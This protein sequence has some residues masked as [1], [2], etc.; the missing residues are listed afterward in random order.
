MYLSGKRGLAALALLFGLLASCQKNEIDPTPDTSLTDS[1]STSQ[2]GRNYSAVNAWV[3][4]VMNDAYYWYRQLPAQASLDASQSPFDYFEKLVYEP[5]TLDRFSGL[6]DDIDALQSE[7]D[8]VSKIFGISYVLAF[9]D[10]SQS[11]IG[12]FLSYVVKGSPADLAGLKRGDV[13]LWVNGQPLTA[14]NYASLL[15][16]NETLSFT[17]GTLQGTTLVANTQRTFTVSKAV[18]TEDPVA[19]STVIDKSAYGKKIGYLLYT[20]FIPGLEGGDAQK[21][22]NELRQVF[23]NFKSQGVNELVL[24]LRLNGGGYISSANTL[25]SLIVKNATASSVFYKEEWND[26]YTAYWQRSGGT[27]ALSYPFQNEPNNIGSQLE[28]VFVLTSNGTASASEL[29]ING[30]TPYMNVVTVGENTYGKNLFG[31]LIDDEQNRWKWGLYVM[32]GRTVNARGQ[33]DYGTVN[34]LTPT[35]Y[36]ED[37]AI[38][39]Q[40]FGDENE[41]LLRKVL[42]VMGVPTGTTAR[43]AATRQVS[44]LST[45]HWKDNLQER[46]KRMIKAKGFK[47]LP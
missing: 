38:P 39:F 25:A 30:L 8:G 7:F 16:S 9:T 14:A 34:G 44:T 41:T 28:R 23:A 47:V 3:Y 17:L 42:D 12:A 31:T 22:D 46:D 1:T 18:V 24:D 21:Y 29:V 43:L 13:I 32:L 26:K 19:F 35:H 45:Q 27:N 33:S 37:T 36:L 15:G 11:N 20:Q 2:S 5:Q 6:T 10:E 4:E 40:A